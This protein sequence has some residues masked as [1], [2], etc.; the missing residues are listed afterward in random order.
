MG[1]LS[2]PWSISP[3]CCGA[4][5]QVVALVPVVLSHVCY[6]HAC[7]VGRSTPSAIVMQVRN[8]PPNSHPLS[9]PTYHSPPLSPNTITHHFPPV[10]P[11]CARPRAAA[12]QRREPR[13]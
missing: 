12:H 7:I 1:M 5:V 13:S 11:T 10:P 3:I 8:P 9:H 4:G 2:V 6:K